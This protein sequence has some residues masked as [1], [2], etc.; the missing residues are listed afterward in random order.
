MSR[1]LRFSILGDSVWRCPGVPVK[2]RLRVR[3]GEALRARG[4]DVTLRNNSLEGATSRAGI[5]SLGWVLSYRPDI[6]LVSLGANDSFNW[7]TDNIDTV[8][9]NLGAIIDGLRRAGVVVLLAG[10]RVRY[11]FEWRFKWRM[12]SKALLNSVLEACRSPFFFD[13]NSMQYTRRFNGLYKRVA[14]R[15]GVPLYPYLLDGVESDMWYD[16]YH[17][18]ARGVDCVVERLAPFIAENLD[19]L[20]SVAASDEATAPAKAHAAPGPQR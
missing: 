16:M 12:F 6:V 7:G 19:Q 15:H 18:N 3:L 17:V 11:D 20:G 8:E 5:D 2:A 4:Y 14:E 10:M 9:R 1:P 13:A